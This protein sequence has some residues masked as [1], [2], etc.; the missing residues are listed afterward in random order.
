MRLLILATL[1][2]APLAAQQQPVRIGVYDTRAIAVAY[3]HSSYNQEPLKA[4]MKE[5]E[6]AK[7]AGDTARVKELDHWGQTQQRKLHFQGFSRVPVA[8]LLVHVK[9]RLPEAAARANVQAIAAD[10][11][12]L[13]PG[14]E[15]IDLTDELVRLYNPSPRVLSIVK[16]MK[17]K[18][19][20]PI[21]EVDKLKP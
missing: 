21:E 14:V 4:K 15:T 17:G 11:D 10:C 3:A 20:L 1:F 16:D 6:A 18:A 9:D 8:D 7:A 5:F 19:P 12:Y 2:A 13:A